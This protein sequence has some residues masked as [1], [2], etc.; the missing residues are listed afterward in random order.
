MRTKYLF[1][2]LCLFAGLTMCYGDA[3]PTGYT[4]VTNISTLQN[5]DHVV[6]YSPTLQGGITG[7]DGKVDATMAQNGWAEYIVETA[8]GGVYLKDAA[9]G[10]YIS[11][12]ISTT[13]AYSDTP[14]LCMLG[15]SS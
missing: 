13:F 6:L 9:V 7:W 2:F 14:I 8:I 4:M 10:K 12:P 3:L 15:T 1:S 11:N 5:G